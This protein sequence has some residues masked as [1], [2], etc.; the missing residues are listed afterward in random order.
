MEEPTI[1]VEVEPLPFKW[2]EVFSLS[3]AQPQEESPYALRKIIFLGLIPSL[4]LA[5]KKNLVI[6]M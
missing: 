1:V 5:S 3:P 4:I 2:K 6:L